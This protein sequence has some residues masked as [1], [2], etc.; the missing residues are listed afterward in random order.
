[1]ALKMIATIHTT[2]CVPRRLSCIVRCIAPR[3]SISSLNPAMKPTTSTQMMSSPMECMSSIC[4]VAS[5]AASSLD[6][7]HCSRPPIHEG[8][9]MAS[10][11]STSQFMAGSER[12]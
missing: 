6:R 7:I 11:A 12:T 9:V 10:L 1:M 2:A 3:K 8:N 5:I 4:L